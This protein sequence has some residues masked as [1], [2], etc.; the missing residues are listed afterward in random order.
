[1]KE[2]V[3]IIISSSAFLFFMEAVHP[4]FWRLKLHVTVFNSTAHWQLHSVFKSWLD[5]VCIF[6][7]KQQCGRQCLV[8]LTCTRLLMYVITY[9]GCVS[10]AW[11]SVVKADYGE[12]NPLPPHRGSA[13]KADWDK[14]NPLLH[15]RGSAVKA[16]WDKNPLPHNIRSVV[17]FDWG[18]NPFAT[19]QRV[20]SEIWLWEGCWGGGGWGGVYCHTIE[21]LQWHLTG[22]EK[23]PSPYHRGST[24]KAEWEKGKKIL[25]TTQKVC[26][27]RENPLPHHR[28][29]AVKV[30]GGCG[31][32]GWEKIPC[33]NIEGLQWKLNVGENPLSHH[34]G[35]AVKAECGRKSLVTPQR[36]CSES[37]MWEKIPCHTTEGLQWKLN[38]G[39]NPLSHHRGSAVKADW[40]KNPLS[41]HRGSAVKADWGTKI[42]SHTT[43]GL[44]WK[45]TEGQ[46]S[47]VTPQR[48]CSESWLSDN[49]PLSHQ[50]IW[51]AWAMWQTQHSAFISC[52]TP[53]INGMLLFMADPLQHLELGLQGP[54]IL[55]I[56]IFIP[57]F[58]CEIYVC[59]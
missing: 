19:P 39:E 42:P 35:S 1:M 9:G 54:Q 51:P 25:A 45:L 52:F 50:G 57:S 46:K 58:S 27:K 2:N 28:R 22:G 20:C 48:V 17:K 44:Q 6:V 29:S 47:L 21:G 34:R 55:S 10:T 13:V 36:V 14:K 30:D 41:H 38:V 53:R 32:W 33:H 40:D 5:V 11:E 24:V 56:K 16:D 7:S 12:K 37:W 31:G 49:N 15:H 3:T 59:L 8:F 43:E 4:F 18:G 23:N 26:S